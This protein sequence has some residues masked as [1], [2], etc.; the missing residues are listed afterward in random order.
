MPYVNNSRVIFLKCVIRFLS[1]SLSIAYKFLPD[2]FP[3][4]F[5]FPE[6]T[7][8]SNNMSYAFT[9]SAFSV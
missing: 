1:N 8:H 3:A 7:L 4:I 2:L 6:P 9:N 5:N